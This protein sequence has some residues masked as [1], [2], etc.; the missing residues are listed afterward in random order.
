M[1]RKKKRYAFFNSL[2]IWLGIVLTLLTIVSA[3]S[4]RFAPG[5]FWPASVAGLFFPW[6]LWANVL[7]FIYRT[8][9][10][11]WRALL[12]LFTVLAVL[13]QSGRLVRLQLPGN[14]EPSN[15]KVLT[16]NLQSLLGVRY[17]K[18]EDPS[19]MEKLLVFLKKNGSDV[20]CFQEFPRYKKEGTDFAKMLRNLGYD[21]EYLPSRMSVGIFSKYPFQEKKIYSK[22]N[23]YNAVIYA[24]VLINGEV[25]RVYNLHLLSNQITSKTEKLI[26][27]SKLSSLSEKKTWSTLRYVMA[28][29]YR[30]S[31]IRVAQIKELLKSVNNCPYPFI[32]CGDFND[33]PWSH[34]Y[35]LIS[36]ELR[37][38]FI[39]AGSGMDVTYRGRVPAL[40]IDY[41]FA[42]KEVTFKRYETLS[43]AF[44]DHYPVETILSLG[45]G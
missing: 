41:I 2:M 31:Q 10:K 14:T 37:D 12:P 26:R 30:T 34:S 18:E 39:E 29:Y 27:D 24:D 20:L 4:G 19:R 45:S 23:S 33:T 1:G 21:Y 3:Y 13:P 43:A 36:Q 22:E 17:G 44:S 11:S 38:G 8:F 9:R 28:M 15:L 16:Y 7:V 42:G 5:S 40:R 32:V 6:L 25:L 35:H